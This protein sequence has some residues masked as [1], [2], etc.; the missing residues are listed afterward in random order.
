MTTIKRNQNKSSV[1]DWIVRLLKGVLVGIGFITPGLSGGVLAVVFGLYEPLMRFLGNLKD[2]FI[3]NVL[4][5]IPV[6]IGGVIGIVAF[7]AVV[8]FAFRNYAAQFTWLLLVSLLAPSLLSSK[9]RGKKAENGGIGS[10]WC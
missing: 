4:Y 9:L 1:F 2:K 10:Y 3:K 8:D 5:F 6:G 7:S